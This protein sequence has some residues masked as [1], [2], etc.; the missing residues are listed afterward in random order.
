MGS[1]LRTLAAAGGA[2]LVVCALALG[3]AMGVGLL[4]RAAWWAAGMG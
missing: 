2:V 4:F 3:A 1:D